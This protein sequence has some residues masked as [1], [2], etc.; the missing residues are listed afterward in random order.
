[1]VVDDGYRLG[2]GDGRCHWSDRDAPID[3]QNGGTRGVVDIVDDGV[4]IGVHNSASWIW[5]RMEKW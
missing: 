5:G 1:L 3:R 4:W 2:S